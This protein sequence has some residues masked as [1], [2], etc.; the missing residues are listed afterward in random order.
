MST[1]N[2]IDMSALLSRVNVINDANLVNVLHD[3][4]IYTVANNSTTVV[5]TLTLL[6]ATAN[7]GVALAY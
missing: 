2:V 1:G 3:S 7:S 5:A 4:R 6:I